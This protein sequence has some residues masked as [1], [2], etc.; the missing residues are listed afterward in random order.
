MSFDLAVEKPAHISASVKRLV[1]D[2]CNQFDD[3]VAV[4]VPIA[5]VFNCE[6]HAV[7]MASPRDLRDFAFGF[8]L[9]EGI[10]KSMD[11]ITSVRA[12]PK[13]S[14]ISLSI[15]IP[16]SRAQALGS[17]A[18]N[19][20]GRT[21]CGLCGIADIAQALRPLSVLPNSP[22]IPSAAIAR[23]LA[24]L[25]DAQA[26]NG[27]T[28]A[29]HAAALA[30]LNGELLCVREDVGRH[31]ALDKLIGAAACKG[32][33]PLSGFVVVT[34]RCSM[35]MVQKTVTFGCPILVSVSA[36]T[37]LALEL[38]SKSNLTIAAFARDTQIN[39]YAHS[40]RIA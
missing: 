13:G 2:S 33:N 31:N 30:G 40:E 37:S 10:V 5:F 9:A 36:P 27:E 19:L 17:R 18:R 38:A 26:V 1:G 28:G 15:Q 23:A 34:S 16:E 22:V 39:L 4:E 29:V 12:E 32:F 7:M 3:R 11:E 25:P 21:G 8:T 24:C 35:E 6:N 14:G 20:E